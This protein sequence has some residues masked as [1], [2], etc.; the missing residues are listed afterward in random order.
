MGVGEDIIHAEEV[1][2]TA[3]EDI[4]TADEVITRAGEDLTTTKKDLN[5]LAAGIMS[6]PKIATHVRE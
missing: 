6:S 4:P 5:S 1:M 2:A 3:V